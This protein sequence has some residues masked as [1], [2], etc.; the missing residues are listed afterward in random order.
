MTG[1]MILCIYCIPG[2]SWGYLGFSPVTPPLPPPPPPQI[3]SPRDN[4][5]NILLRP[6]KFGVGVHMG[7]G[8]KPIVRWPWPSRNRPMK[9]T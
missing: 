7:D 5:K 2:Q 1:I 4:S 8:S 3:S 9:A 6:F